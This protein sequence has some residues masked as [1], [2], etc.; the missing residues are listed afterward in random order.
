MKTRN[1]RR[2]PSHDPQTGQENPEYPIMACMD[3][4]DSNSPYNYKEKSQYTRRDDIIPKKYSYQ[5]MKCPVCNTY[6][7]LYYTD[8]YGYPEIM[9]EY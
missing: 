7:I 4:C 8:S 6:T 5:E 9:V 3:C 1:F 2:I